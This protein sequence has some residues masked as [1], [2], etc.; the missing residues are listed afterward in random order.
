MK[1]RRTYRDQFYDSDLDREATVEAMKRYPDADRTSMEFDQRVWQVRQE[2][3]KKMEKWQTQFSIDVMFDLD[4]M[5]ATVCEVTP[6]GDPPPAYQPY[7][8][9]PPLPPLT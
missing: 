2:I 3:E 1:F 5:T 7:I 8:P 9:N 6:K 4:N